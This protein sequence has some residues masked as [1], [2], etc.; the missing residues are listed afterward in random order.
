MWCR[1]DGSVGGRG[2]MLTEP[3]PRETALSDTKVL[4]V[5]MG[6]PKTRRIIP[7]RGSRGTP[8]RSCGCPLGA[9]ASPP[10]TSREGSSTFLHQKPPEGPP[11]PQQAQGSIRSGCRIHSDPCGDQRGTGPA[12]RAKTR[13]CRS[14]TAGSTS[15][16]GGGGPLAFAYHR[17]AMCHAE[18]PISWSERA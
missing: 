3:L 10:T 2:V 14:C 5:S 4:R 15:N 11:V 9:A 6:Q 18:T 13:R 1:R 7:V 17:R 16:A 12:S 8:G